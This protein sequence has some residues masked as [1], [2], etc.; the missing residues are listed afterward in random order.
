MK[1]FGVKEEH[2]NPEGLTREQ[3]I[4]KHK[5]I[6]NIARLCWYIG[7]EPEQFK[8]ELE[9]LMKKDFAE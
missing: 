5:D 3:F 7:V 9:I 1:M 2:K 8:K 6:E 4:E